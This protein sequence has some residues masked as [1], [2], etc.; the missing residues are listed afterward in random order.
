M[1]RLDDEHYMRL[2][3]E[4]ARKAFAQCE[5]PVG[6]VAV[7]RGHI[8]GQ[9]YNRKETS[10]DPTAHAEIIALQEAAQTRGGWRL[11]NVTLYC[12]MEP[13]PMCAGAM[14]QARLSRLVYAVTDPKAG[15]AGSVLNLLAHHG[16]NHY[17]AITQGVLASETE[18][19]L[20]DFFSRLRS[21]EI[22]RFS[23]SW[24]HRKLAEIDDSV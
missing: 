6:A 5:I 7:Y 23:E 14:V 18:A 1:S 16:L 3:L 21:G 13:C 19:L 17:V 22:P 11:H 4:Q 20:T 9:G 2:A 24:R 10:R 12:T 8:I 15:A